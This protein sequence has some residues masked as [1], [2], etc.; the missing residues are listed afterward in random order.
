MKRTAN[1]KAL[2]TDEIPL[3]VAKIIIEYLPDAK[4]FLFGSRAKGCAKERSDFDIAIYNKKK[5]PLDVMAKIKEE[6][7]ELPTLKSID[8]VDLNRVNEKFKDSVMRDGVLID[9]R[10][11]FAT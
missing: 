4:V 9:V 7:E 1:L 8:I 5:I 6:V 10:S 3:A 2:N 11:K